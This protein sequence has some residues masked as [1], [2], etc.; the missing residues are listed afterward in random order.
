MQVSGVEA[1][2]R[3]GDRKHKNDSDHPSDRDPSPTVVGLGL[4][5]LGTVRPTIALI[6]TGSRLVVMQTPGRLR[7]HHCS[8]AHAVRSGLRAPKLRPASRLGR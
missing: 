8:A 7:A 6:F 4:F 3:D 2:H 5:L 1:G